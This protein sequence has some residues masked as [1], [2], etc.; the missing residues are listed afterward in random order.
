MTDS[1][2]RQGVAASRVVGFLGLESLVAVLA[3]MPALPAPVARLLGIS[4]VIV[5]V[6]LLLLAIMEIAGA[7]TA[8][9]LRKPT[10]RIVTSGIFCITRNPVYLSMILLVIGIGLALNSVWSIL[11][12]APM[13][14]VFYLTII[15]PEERYLEGKFGDAHRAYC[16]EAPRWLSTRRLF[17]A[18]RARP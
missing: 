16:A 3:P 1:A 7:K 10:T 18:F 14:S 5:S 13:G 12:A 8:F 6:A 4:V 17:G 15:S 9:D 11:L 2:E